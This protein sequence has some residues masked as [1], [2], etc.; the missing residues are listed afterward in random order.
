MRYS[1]TVSATLIFMCLAAA[2]MTKAQSFDGSNGSGMCERN[3]PTCRSLELT[4]THLLQGR[5]IRRHFSHRTFQIQ[6]V[7]TCRLFRPIMEL[8]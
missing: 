4:P 1:K 8:R 3:P 7:E 6:M 5:I 2:S